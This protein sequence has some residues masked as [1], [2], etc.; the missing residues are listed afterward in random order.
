[1][2]FRIRHSARCSGTTRP[3]AQKTTNIPLHKRIEWADEWDL[4]GFNA[5]ARFLLLRLA[6]HYD[7]KAGCC[8]YG[9]AALAER[10]GLSTQTVKNS[11]RDLEEAGIV[12]VER[13]HRKTNRYVLDFSS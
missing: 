2:G 4:T 11:L 3:G 8:R 5:S 13:S 12:T 1:M 10:M 9:Q 6:I 7:A